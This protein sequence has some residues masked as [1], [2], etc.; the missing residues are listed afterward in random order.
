MSPICIVVVLPWSLT[1]LLWRSS[2]RPPGRL[3]A[4]A[5][6]VGIYKMN[7]V[8]VVSLLALKSGRRV[9]RSNHNATL[10]DGRLAVKRIKV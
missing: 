7:L 9:R 4:T 8:K 10:A 2:V 6:L 1:I 3:F 5:L